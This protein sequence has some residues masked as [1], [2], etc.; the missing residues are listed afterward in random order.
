MANPDS[1]VQERPSGS[2]CIDFPFSLR[3]R[4]RA[5]GLLPAFA[6][7]EYFVQTEEAEDQKGDEW[8]AK[9]KYIPTRPG[10]VVSTVTSSEPRRFWHL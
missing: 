4:S 7:G 10:R 6:G 2:L 9:E 3:G 1:I 8:D 5:R